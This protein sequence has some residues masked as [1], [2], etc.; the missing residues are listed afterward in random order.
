M[1]NVL[2]RLARPHPAPGTPST[3][4]GQLDTVSPR[5]AMSAASVSG[6]VRDSQSIGVLTTPGDQLPPPQRPLSAPSVQDRPRLRD[7]PAPMS[8]I[9]AHSVHSVPPAIASSTGS[10]GTPWSRPD[11]MGV[12]LHEPVPSHI[13]ATV[14]PSLMPNPAAEAV[15]AATG[16][17]AFDGHRPNGFPSHIVRSMSPS[18]MSEDD[19][20]E[21]AMEGEPFRHFTQREEELHFMDQG[22]HLGIAAKKREGSKTSRD[23]KRRRTEGPDGVA[24][25]VEW[26]PSPIREKGDPI[27]DSSDPISMGYLSVDEGQ[28]LFQAFFKY[29]HPFVPVFDPREDTWERSVLFFHP[30]EWM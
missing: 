19:A 25:D 29:A 14:M 9:S 1:S 22:F 12:P 8:V 28:R 18:T 27:R 17:G 26:I 24:H 11:D 10:I 5:T 13:H 16:V 6:Y 23:T 20:L 30:T 7:Y 21:S 15:A 2:F 3:T 4:E